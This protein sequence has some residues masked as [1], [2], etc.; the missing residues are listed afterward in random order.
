MTDKIC[1]ELL[2]ITKELT[3]RIKGSHDASERDLR[4]GYWNK[5]L[6]IITDAIVRLQ[7]IEA[8]NRNEIVNLNK[9][10]HDNNIF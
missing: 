3:D 8:K 2:T 10:K 5:S 1:D 4:L 6:R 7:E 9:S